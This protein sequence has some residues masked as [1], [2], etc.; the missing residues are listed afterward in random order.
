MFKSN[1]E[2]FIKVDI[3]IQQISYKPKVMVVFKSVITSNNWTLNAYTQK[4]YFYIQFKNVGPN[5]I[6]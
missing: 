4:L 1:T 2:I 6:F 5:H 3:M